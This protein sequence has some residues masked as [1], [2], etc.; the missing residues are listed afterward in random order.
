[1]AIKGVITN[2]DGGEESSIDLQ[3]DGKII[4]GGNYS[5]D[6]GRYYALARYNNN[7]SLDATF[8]SD[9]KGTTSF[10]LLLLVRAMTIQGDGKILVAG[11]SHNGSNYDFGLVRYNN[12]GSLDVTFDGDGKVITTLGGDS[13]S[14]TATDMV[15]QPDGKIL[16]A[17]GITSSDF[18]YRDF[19]LVRYNS[20]GSLDA[21]F[22]NDGKVTT[23]FGGKDYSPKITLQADGKILVAGVSGT[24]SDSSKVTVDNT[25][26]ALARYNADGSLDIT[27]DGDGAYSD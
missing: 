11:F 8:D 23:D 3:S 10:P 9:G 4:V 17:G 22:D 26:F 27:F 18:M 25:D 5:S 2:F 14:E 6:N 15:L 16:V 24:N 20:D 13:D 19:A 1:M 7:G 21:T 12:N